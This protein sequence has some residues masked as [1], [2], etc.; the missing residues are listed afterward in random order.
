MR[1]L[2]GKVIPVL[3]VA[4]AALAWS[5]PAGAFHAVDAHDVNVPALA[6]GADAPSLDACSSSGP[7]PTGPSRA[8]TDPAAESD[9][10]TV[11]SEQP[12]PEALV[13]FGG[14]GLD[15]PRSSRLDLRSTSAEDTMDRAIL[16]VVQPPRG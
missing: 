6:C 2:L 9:S 16:P 14:S 11:G 10:D 4:I 13:A 1:S 5:L 15:A 12:A 3:A 7:V 8:E